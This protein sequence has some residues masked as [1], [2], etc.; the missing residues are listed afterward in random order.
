MGKVITAYRTHP[1]HGSPVSQTRVAAWARCAQPHVSRIENGNAIDSI[2]KLE[3]WS[4]LLGIP[5]HLQWIASTGKKPDSNALPIKLENQEIPSG[6][7]PS[8]QAGPAFSKTVEVNRREFIQ[9]GI[10]MSLT[11][12]VDSKVATSHTVNP[13]IFKNFVSMRTVLVSSD[14]MLGPG[15]LI[16][17]TAEQIDNIQS[18]FKRADSSLRVKLFEI[19]GLFAEFQGW[20]MDDLGKLNE[21]R[22]WSRQALE[23]VETVGNENLAAYILMRMSQQAQLAGDTYAVKGL[24]NA[25][26]RRDRAVVTKIVQAAVTQQAAHGYALEGDENKSLTLLDKA[27]DLVNES[28]QSDN[29]PYEMAGYCTTSYV[30]AQRG[31][32]LSTLGKHNQALQAFDD[33]LNYWPQD[34]R[35]ER[36][37][38]LARQTFAAVVANRPDYVNAV[39]AEALQIARETGSRR[40]LRELERAAETMASWSYNSDVKELRDS[41]NSERSASGNYD[42]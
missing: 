42:R 35:R 7:T 27:H 19:A 22:A 40:T 17:T 11:T 16:A 18:L 29:D 25:A 33:S 9:T 37:L 39:G 14:S 15:R 34:Y 3:F 12:I 13:G 24:A 23:W 31:A 10:A 6:S 5:K 32:I 26:A 28:G 21:G 36:G 20:L 8:S 41:I 30:E 1:F 38:H 2:A 4:S